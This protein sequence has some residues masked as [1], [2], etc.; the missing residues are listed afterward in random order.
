MK[1]KLSKRFIIITAFVLVA[2][3]WYVYHRSSSSQAMPLVATV[4][5]IKIKE[6]L[7]P[8]NIQVIGTLSA[9]SVEISP[10][11]S[12]HVNAVLALDGSQVKKGQ[13]IIQLDDAIYKAKSDSSK[14]QLIYSE[15]NYK[16]MVLLGKQGAISKQA[17]DAAD[18]DLKQKRA[19]SLE[20]E[21]MTKKMQL[22]APFDGVIGKVNI[23][24]GDYVT[25]GQG[26][27]TLTDINH[28]RIEYTVPE[29]YLTQI[30][31]GQEVNIT[32]GTYH[33]K[34]F[35][36]KVAFISPTINPMNRS[37][38]LYADIS[39]DDHLLA[40][41]MFVT[42]RQSLGEQ[43][44]ALMIPAR[45]AVAALDGQQIYKIINDKAVPVTVKLGMRQQ[46]MVEVTEGLAPGD[47]IV[48]DGQIKLRN[49]SPVKVVV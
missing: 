41:G 25:V 15:N 1:I 31:I 11:I 14:A 26:L 21:V 9:Q 2:L 19:E 37:V 48:T 35:T 24:P 8:V 27:V 43:S 29:T 12:G 44:H 42:V 18:A 16:R 39:N 5:T 36:G 49:G 28:L 47:I 7:I 17:I 40:P 22:I 38:Q 30:K 3:A 32:S 20:N 45:S 10:E 4:K 23:N 6:S 13:A 34:T 46:D 33:A